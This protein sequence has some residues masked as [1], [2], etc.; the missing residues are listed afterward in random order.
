[1]IPALVTVDHA[2]VHLRTLEFSYEDVLLKTEQ[3]TAI[4]MDH[5]KL[6]AIPSAWFSA[7][8][9]KASAR[10]QSYWVQTE[11]ENL[12]PAELHYVVV[13]GVIE[14]AIILQTAELFEY[15]EGAATQGIADS[16]VHLLE[17]NRTPTV[18]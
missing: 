17:T 14:A 4:V 7:T 3:A 13:P 10:P 11:N 9:P 6:T 12:S 15:R 2:N 16:V 5:I 8:I 18:K 1:M